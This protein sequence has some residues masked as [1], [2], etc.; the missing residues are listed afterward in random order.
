MLL[1]FGFISLRLTLNFAR[2]LFC[3]TISLA[4]KNFKIKI[5]NNTFSHIYYSI[6][7]GSSIWF[8][9]K[10]CLIQDFINIKLTQTYDSY[11]V[12]GE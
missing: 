11:M 4:K 7:V 12:I 10:N 9:N 1:L 3:T 8:N 6:F 5:Q 2:V